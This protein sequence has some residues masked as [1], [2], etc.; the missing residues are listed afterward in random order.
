[1]LVRGL[2]M[3]N[4]FICTEIAPL[5]AL[6]TCG[7]W[8]SG[9]HSAMKA[10]WREEPFCS[11]KLVKELKKTIGENILGEIEHKLLK[12]TLEWAKFQYDKKKYEIQME[13]L[14]DSGAD[15]HMSYGDILQLV[16]NILR[17]KDEDSD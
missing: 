4:D 9:K 11:K 6:E 2:T 3:S 5:Y 17:K 8:F 1:M 15:L 10:V 16:E 12:K 13:L 14:I 7:N